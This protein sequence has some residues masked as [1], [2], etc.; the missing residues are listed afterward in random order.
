MLYQDIGLHHHDR[1]SS[2]EPLHDTR[3]LLRNRIEV[4]RTIKSRANALG[5]LI[6]LDQNGQAR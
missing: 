4:T 3:V 1:T 5:S 2:P 6:V